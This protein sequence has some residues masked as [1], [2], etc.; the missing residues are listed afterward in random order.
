MSL[1]RIALPSGEWAEVETRITYGVR[2]RVSLGMLHARQ[3]EDLEAKVAADGEVVLAMV[4]RWSLVSLEGQPLELNETGIDLAD[5]R[6]ITVLFRECA[7]IY[8]EGTDP[9]PKAAPSSPRG[10]RAAARGS[11]E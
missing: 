6:D 11:S 7:R 3:S 9:D 8:R 5:S 10:R 4:V 2:R 1:E